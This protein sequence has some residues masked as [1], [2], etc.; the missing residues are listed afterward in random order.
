MGVGMLLVMGWDGVGER[1][2]IEGREGSVSGALSGLR[3]PELAL[4][5]VGI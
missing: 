3:T 1:L 4:R 5:V 2:L